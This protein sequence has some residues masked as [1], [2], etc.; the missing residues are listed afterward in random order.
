[1]LAL[2]SRHHDIRPHRRLRKRYRHHAVQVIPFALEERV[3]FD[4]QHDIQIA[5]RTAKRPRLAVSREPNPRPVF[6]ARRHLRLHHAFAYQPTFTLALRT[7]I[8]NH[9]P[10]TL[11]RRT[12]PRDTEKPL[13]ISHL[14]LPVTSSARCRSLSRRSPVSLARIASLVPP[15]IDLLLRAED[16][17]LKFQMQ[18]FAQIS[19]P[20]CAA[21]TTPTLSEGITEPENVTENIAEILKDRRIKSRRATRIPTHTCMSKAVIQRSLIA[22]GQ[23]RVR[24]R[25]LLKLVF[26]LR[27]VRVPIRMMRHREFSVRALDLNLGRRAGHSQHFIKIAFCISSQKLPPR[28]SQIRSQKSRD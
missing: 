3:L 27:I 10:R 9:A 6:H 1:M 26:R 15:H 8:G 4:V 25:D 11:T 19:P 18:V 17:F 7:R 14:P 22:V 24:L 2:Q 5:R 13:L 28:Y 12:R 16:R 21:A 20:L 23:N